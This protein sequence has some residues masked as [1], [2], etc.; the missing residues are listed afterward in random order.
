MERIDIIAVAKLTPHPHPTPRALACPMGGVSLFRA[1]VPKSLTPVD[2]HGHR[3]MSMNRVD[4]AT[5][6]MLPLLLGVN[7]KYLMPSRQ[8]GQKDSLLRESRH[9]DCCTVALWKDHNECM[10]LLTHSDLQQV[11]GAWTGLILL[12][13]C[14]V[15]RASFLISIYICFSDAILLVFTPCTTPFH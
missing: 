13:V 15:Y 14:S 9:C 1:R 5:S 7:S 12:A 4:T 2:S 10:Q 11:C 3:C 6:A 8:I